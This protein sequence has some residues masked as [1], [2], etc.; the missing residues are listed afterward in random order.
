MN[1]AL[2]ILS[3]AWGGAEEF[4][5]QLAK[6]LTRN[7]HHVSIIANEEVIKYYKKELR[8]NE[9]KLIN[10]G[11]MFKFKILQRLPYVRAIV[12]HYTVSRAYRRLISHLMVEEYDVLHFNQPVVLL[13]VYYLL[14]SGKFSTVKKSSKIVYTA[15]GLDFELN[16]M[17]NTLFPK[18]IIRKLISS[19]DIVTTPSKFMRDELKQNDIIDDIRVIP[20]GIEY[21]T[22]IKVSNS[23]KQEKNRP[24]LWMVFPGGGKLWKGGVEVLKAVHY[25]SSHQ[26]N[27]KLII[28]RPVPKGH[29]Y[30]RLIGSY[31]IN[32]HVSIL[33]LLSRREYYKLLALSDVLIMPSKKEAFGIVFL[34]AMALGKPIIA[35]NMGGI[36]EVVEDRHNGYL[37]DGTPIELAKLIEFLYENPRIQRK[38]SCINPKRANKFDW[39]KIV[40]KYIRLYK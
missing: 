19:F 15:H 26:N 32:E 35:T 2:I 7:G 27:I 31:K 10:L 40:Y 13:L 39:N 22:L 1:I 30:F 3:G 14:L 5:Y 25:L 29:L 36:P 18:P 20:N 4:V 23:Q 21:K 11:E 33:G 8:E 24:E 17:S 6:T 28:T 37:C 38:I 9:I 34:E 12:R 16:R